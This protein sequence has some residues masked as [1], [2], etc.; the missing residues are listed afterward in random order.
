[1]SHANCS[2]LSS[3]QAKLG[4]CIAITLIF[5]VVEFVAG[6]MFHS[7]AL[8][9][10]AGHM[11]TD[12]LA[13][14]VVFVSSFISHFPKNLSKN[15]GYHRVQVL[16]SLINGI[17]L[18]IVSVLIIVEAIERLYH[19]EQTSFKALLTLGSSGLIVNTVVFLII[20]SMGASQI[21]IKGAYLHVLA[22]LLASLTAVAAGVVIYFTGNTLVD[23]ILSIFISFIILWTSVNFIKETINILMEG[24]PKEIPFEKVKSIVH[25]ID[26]SIQEVSELK[27]WS[28]TSQKNFLILR[29]KRNSS[30]QK[31][32]KEIKASLHKEFALEDIFIEEA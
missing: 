14:M 6:K 30:S 10:D 9:S 32:L 13:L 31:P 12:C 22:D 27:C 11:L 2:H 1:M 15:F 16:G 17:L 4:L 3:S 5:M 25:H 26:P 28:L 20:H 21:S 8:V 18:L 24:A 29:I 23:P 7:L 19:P